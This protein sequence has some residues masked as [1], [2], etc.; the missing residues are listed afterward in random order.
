ME[1]ASNCVIPSIRDSGKAM[2]NP[3]DTE[4]TGS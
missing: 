2:V 4:E 1:K 3:E